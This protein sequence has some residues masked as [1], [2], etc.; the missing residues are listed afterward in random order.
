MYLKNFGEFFCDQ[1]EHAG[2]IILS[3]TEGMSEENIYQKYGLGTAQEV[4][5]KLDKAELAAAVT[6]AG[7]TVLIN[8]DFT[9]YTG[10][11][12]GGFNVGIASSNGIITVEDDNGNQY[13]NWGSNPT[14]K[15]DYL[16]LGGGFALNKDKYADPANA[17]VIGAPYVITLTFTMTNASSFL[18]DRSIISECY[19]EIKNN[20]SALNDEIFGFG[21]D[22]A[23]KCLEFY[24]SG[25]LV[26]Y[27]YT[28]GNEVT[29]FKV[30]E[31]V[32]IQITLYHSPRGL[33]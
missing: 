8:T 14:W 7:G 33:N 9:G 6:A 27:N 13:V 24:Y 30:E 2:T 21:V 17:S 1:V 25:S 12:L 18:Y 26:N 10:S 19:T 5:K 22:R 29:D 3:H 23:T 31:G 16:D 11:K 32:P 20:F 15:T 4:Y 28:G